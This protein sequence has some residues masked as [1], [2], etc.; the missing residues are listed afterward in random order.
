ML[1]MPRRC[2][3]LSVSLRPCGFRRVLAVRNAALI[4]LVGAVLAEQHDEFPV[5]SLNAFAWASVEF[6]G[7][8]VEDAWAVE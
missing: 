5:I 1:T 4:G 3:G 7:H 6:G 2:P 8:V